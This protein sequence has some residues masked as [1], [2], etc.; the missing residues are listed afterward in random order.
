MA[1]F[2]VTWSA[3]RRLFE[4]RMRDAQKNVNRELRKTLR[5]AGNRI[6]KDARANIS[7]QTEVKS[8][9]RN[10]AG[11]NLQNLTGSLR[12]GIRVRVR[13]RGRNATVTIA[14]TGKGGFY[15]SLHERGE[16][17]MQRRPFLQPAVDKNAP[18]ILRDFG[19]VFKVV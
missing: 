3:Q 13:T 10:S 14:P 5:Q 17:G 7:G 1:A 11:S 19:L 12:R 16:G 18:G 9:K 15:G 6:R 2:R 4:R 8:R